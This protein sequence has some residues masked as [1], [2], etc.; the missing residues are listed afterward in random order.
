MEKRNGNGG[1]VFLVVVAVVVGLVRWLT[2][3][4]STAILS[5]AEPGPMADVIPDPAPPPRTV[6]AEPA[7]PAGPAAVTENRPAVLTAVNQTPAA[8]VVVKPAAPASSVLAPAKE[9]EYNRIGLNYRRPMPRP[10]VDGLVIDAHTHLFAARHARAWFECCDHFGIDA[11]ITMAPLEEAVGLQRG[12]GHRLKFIAIPNWQD[13]SKNWSENFLIR[14]EAFHNL[15]SRV[16]KFHSAPGSMAAR[17]FRLDDDRCRRVMDE[18]V[19]RGMILM[20]HVGDP[21]TWYN[22]K[23]AADPA[24]YKTRDDDYRMWENCLRDYK[25]HIW[26]GAH[27]GGNPEDL[28]RIQRLLDTYPNLYLDL[29]A[30]RW[31]VREVSNHR[32]QAREF[33]IRNADRLVWGSDQVSGNDR[34]FDFMAS[35]LWAHRKLWETAHVG[36]TPILDPDLPADNQPTLRG[37][38]LP[39]EVL[40]KIYHDTIVALMGRVGVQFER[41]ARMTRAA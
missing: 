41:P 8:P 34:G 20:S 33:V 27:L 15:G 32:D 37:L 35:R 40:Q 7:G 10:P 23:Y 22:G 13:T 17:G 26:W 18:A 24:K 3:R 11:C 5:R 29:S 12:W 25:D 21:D 4:R 31:M 6:A 1:F 19:A 38:A 28:P 14:L 2:R 36:P 16:V 30:T 9:T 39:D